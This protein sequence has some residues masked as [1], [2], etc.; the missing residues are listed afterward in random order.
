MRNQAKAYF[1]TRPNPTATAEPP[2]RNRFYALKG[3]ETQEKSADVVTGAL[4]VFYF[5][6]YALSDPGSTLSFATPLV[7]SKFHLLL[8]ILHEP[9]LV[10]TPIG[11]SIRDERV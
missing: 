2:K 7:A 8:E 3:R 9:F 11:K 10:C 4:H 6:V 5:P 1:Q